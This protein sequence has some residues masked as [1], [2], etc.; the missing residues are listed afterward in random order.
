LI[1]NLGDVNDKL[2][3]L[4]KLKKELVG[5]KQETQITVDKAI[6]VGSTADLLKKVRNNVDSES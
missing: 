3:N 4:H 1:K 5:Q 2:M 6:F